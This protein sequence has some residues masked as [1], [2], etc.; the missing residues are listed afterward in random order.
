MIA[1]RIII[2]TIYNITIYSQAWHCYPILYYI[3]DRNR[4]D[5][6]HKSS[7]DLTLQ[8]FEIIQLL[9]DLCLM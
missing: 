9:D 8:L 2:R 3:L 6:N 7:S 4:F 5:I 1:V